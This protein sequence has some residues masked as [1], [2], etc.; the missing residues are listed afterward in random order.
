MLTVL[1]FFVDC[2]KK[3]FRVLESVVFSIDGAYYTW[4]A[5]LISY[6]VLCMVISVFWKG[7]RK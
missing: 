1:E 3:L 7:V 4:G 6:V 5:I 2:L